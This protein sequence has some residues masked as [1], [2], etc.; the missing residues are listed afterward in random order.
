[1][2]RRQ[3]INRRVN[4]GLTHIEPITLRVDLRFE[5]HGEPFR[6]VYNFNR[7]LFD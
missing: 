4:S 6:E 3:R 2:C 5:A 1:M 7:I